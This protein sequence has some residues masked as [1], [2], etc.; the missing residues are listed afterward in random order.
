MRR[1]KLPEQRARVAAEVV[2]LERQL[3]D[4]LGQHRQ[5]VT[6][7]EPG[8]HQVRPAAGAAQHRGREVCRRDHDELAV[9]VPQLLLEQRTRGISARRRR[10]QQHD[11]LGQRALVHKPAVAIE[12]QPRLAAAGGAQNQQRTAGVSD[13]RGRIVSGQSSVGHVV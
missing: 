4:P 2:V 11:P 10:R 1:T 6:G 12:D 13:Q 9:A 8:V 3:V 7:A 5:P